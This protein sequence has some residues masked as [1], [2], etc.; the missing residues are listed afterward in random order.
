MEA[1]DPVE[2]TSADVF[3]GVAAMYVLTPG[4]AF[5]VVHLAAA[6]AAAPFAP[7]LPPAAGPGI[8]PVAPVVN[9]AVKA[10]R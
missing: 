5:L 1:F 9:V 7:A 10:A 6:A 4:L 8:G 3:L 2:R